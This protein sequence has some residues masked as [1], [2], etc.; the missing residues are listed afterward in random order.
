MSH[1]RGIYRQRIGS[2]SSPIQLPCPADSPHS[3]KPAKVF[4]HFFFLG[5]LPYSTTERMTVFR[6][7]RGRAAPVGWKEMELSSRRVSSKNVSRGRLSSRS[8]IPVNGEVVGPVV[9][10]HLAG[11]CL[12]ATV[13]K[14]V[15]T[16]IWGFTVAVLGA[17]VSLWSSF[18]PGSLPGG[19]HLF[20]FECLRGGWGLGLV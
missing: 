8:E 17:A 15:V 9:T 20:L 13:L 1:F 5:V 18:G 3:C 2:E 12:S 6:K 19:G 14:A 16:W 4:T 7:A 11:L 10:T